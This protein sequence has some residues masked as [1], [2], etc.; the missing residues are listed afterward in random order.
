V[1]RAGGAAFLNFIAYGPE[2]NFTQPP[3]PQDARQ[4]WEP[5]WTVKARFKST[6]S[7]LLGQ[8][9]DDD[10]RRPSRS[11]RQTREA[12]E[13]SEGQP[14]QPPRQQ[15]SAPDPVQDGVNILRGIFGR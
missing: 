15:Q 5:L 13:G 14:A 2:A 1:R 8:A 3:R 10:R 6:A 4:P 11:P 9:A 12:S 7:T